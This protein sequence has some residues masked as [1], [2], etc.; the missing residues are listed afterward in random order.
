M[1]TFQLVADLRL[2]TGGSKSTSFERYEEKRWGNVAENV[3]FTGESG[4]INRVKGK[5][6]QWGQFSCHESRQMIHFLKGL[7]E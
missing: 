1:K 7:I 3:K 5:K 6:F 4:N 2:R